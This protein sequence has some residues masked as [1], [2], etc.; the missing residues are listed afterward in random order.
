MNKIRDKG[1]MWKE[2]SYNPAGGN[3]PQIFDIVLLR[4][5]EIRPVLE[6]Y[7]YGTNEQKAQ[8]IRCKNRWLRLLAVKYMVP[9]KDT[10]WT[11]DKMNKILDRVLTWG[12]NGL[13][14]TR[15]G[16][17]TKIPDILVAQIKK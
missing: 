2:S 13:Q 8:I 9:N 12:G 10:Y 16:Q 14:P 11:K 6:Q 1:I 15:R 7:W 5:L 3:E 4:L 17:W